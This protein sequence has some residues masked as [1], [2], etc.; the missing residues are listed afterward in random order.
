MRAAS[1]RQ[2]LPDPSLAL[3]V[4]HLFFIAMNRG[5]NV[6][7]IA[8]W[9][10]FLNCVPLRQDRAGSGSGSCDLLYAPQLGTESPVPGAFF[11][12]E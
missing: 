11:N 9:S 6:R 2:V 3:P 10:D 4:V 12:P 1:E 8:R 5:S 7:C